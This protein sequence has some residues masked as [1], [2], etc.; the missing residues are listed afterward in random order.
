QREVIAL[1]YQVG[2][3][4][5]PTLAPIAAWAIFSRHFIETLLRPP[6]E[7][8]APVPRRSPQGDDGAT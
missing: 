8:I 3:L 6:P 1:G 4:I 2:S 5:L 7:A